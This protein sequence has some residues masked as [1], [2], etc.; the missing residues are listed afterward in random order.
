MSTSSKGMWLTLVAGA[1]WG[2]SGVSGEYLMDHG[3]PVQWITAVRLLVSGFVLLVFAWIS[4]REQLVAALKSKRALLGIFL[5]S[6]FGLMINQIAYLSAIEHTNAGTAT[7]LQYLCPVIV[8]T[9]TSFRERE[10]PGIIEIVAVA[11]AVL[12]TFLIA[13][14]GHLSS[15]AMTPAGLFWGL[16]SAL[17]YALY[18]LIPSRLI[19]QYGTLPVMSIGM[20]MG[21]V[22]VSCTFQTWAYTFHGDGRQWLALFGIVGIGTIFAYTVFLKGVSIIGSVKGSLLA[23]VEPVSSVLFGMILL[24]E[25]FYEMDLLGM[26][27]ILAAVLLISLRDLMIEQRNS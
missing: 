12:G 20:L 3:V 2:L 21:G 18:I 23:S 27:V 13:T 19:R 17:T 14:H 16:F 26:L 7:V 24:Q 25:V 11:L 5:F 22:A 15:L 10:W 9:Y 6:F 4:A 8:L 1:A